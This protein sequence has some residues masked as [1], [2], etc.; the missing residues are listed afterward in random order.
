M[1]YQQLAKELPNIFDAEG[2]KVSEDI[3][4]TQGN[5][6]LEGESVKF[7]KLLAEIQN[8]ITMQG[9]NFFCPENSKYLIAL[10]QL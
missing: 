8:L 5:Y 1:R 7:S 9:E 3:Y 6:L 4:L 2:A 10:S